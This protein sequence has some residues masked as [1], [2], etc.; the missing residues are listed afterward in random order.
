MMCDTKEE[1]T[2]VYN[3]ESEFL[4]DGSNYY[5]RD[6]LPRPFIIDLPGPFPKRFARGENVKLRLTLIGNARNHF[7]CFLE[8]M[9]EMCR[10]GL[11][12][13]PKKFRI[14]KIA[15]IGVFTD[16]LLEEHEPP[17]D[18]RK[19]IGKGREIDFRSLVQKARSIPSD[20]IRLKFLTPTMIP[21]GRYCL[22]RP[23]FGY[24]LTELVNRINGLV[25]Y[26]G[27]NGNGSS[28]KISHADLNGR[29]RGISLSED[30]I[31]W[32][33]LKRFSQGARRYRKGGF[34]GEIEWKGDFEDLMPFFLLG[35]LIHIGRQSP[36]GSGQFQIVHE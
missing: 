13:R 16:E 24:F 8:T 10:L 2:Y 3:F 36:Y 15:N 5:T 25:F 14:L 22:T 26:T 20:R 7:D 21:N 32:V 12:S 4:K 33:P 35:E 6:S 17:F 34:V 23:D 1:C 11:P 30:R 29:D 31:V 9:E 18:A 28:Q 27:C 19:V